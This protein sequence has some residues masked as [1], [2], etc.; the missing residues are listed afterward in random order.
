MPFL[1][2]QRWGNLFEFIFYVNLFRYLLWMGLGLVTI[3]NINFVLFLVLA[4]L[5]LASIYIEARVLDYGLGK[6]YNPVLKALESEY[7]QRKN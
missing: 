2:N 1:K 4:V 6:F 5:I 3:I 7:S